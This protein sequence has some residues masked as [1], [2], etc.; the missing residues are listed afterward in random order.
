MLSVKK[1]RKPS[2]PKK[3]R[4]KKKQKDGAPQQ[5]HGGRGGGG[6]RH[7]ARLA[8]IDSG[9]AWWW[10]LVSPEVPGR[11]AR[12]VESASCFGDSSLAAFGFPRAELQAL[13]LSDG[14]PGGDPPEQRRA[15]IARLASPEVLRR[16]L[17]A[18]EEPEAREDLLDRATG[19]DARALDAM[20]SALKDA[21]AAGAPLDHPCWEALLS[22]NLI[23][24]LRDGGLVASL[25]LEATPPLELAGVAAAFAAVF[26]R[27]RSD[28]SLTET[29][30]EQ[31]IT[32]AASAELA[33]TVVD[34]LWASP[35]L[36]CMFD[37][38]ETLDLW[39]V[40]ALAV[41]RLASL[42]AERAS[43]RAPLL[44]LAEEA[45]RRAVTPDTVDE[46]V[47]RNLHALTGA[48]DLE[49]HAHGCEG[50]PGEIGR[51]VRAATLAFL[52]APPDRNAY[53][54]RSYAE[55][56]GGA[57]STGDVDEWYLHEELSEDP[58]DVDALEEL[59][60]LLD[61]GFEQPERAERVRCY[62][63]W[64]DDEPDRFSTWPPGPAAGEVPT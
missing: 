8:P 15:L 30:A 49:R 25:L 53:L 52:M 31:G 16:S 7:D 29:L 12:F 60:E 9:E 62:L 50:D 37:F 63:D 44:A 23:L 18:L 35:E 13:L 56:L 6:D 24:A 54:R 48:G 41:R 1:N 36:P 39:R 33:S 19:D 34:D 42:P 64:L 32:E 27:S 55:A 47:H 45:Y 5:R 11:L 61:D 4:K 46:L 59:E 17:A 26:E 22:F 38:E 57:L 21:L 2:K 43:S 10:A 20:T 58:E 14:P 28:P 3:K 51:R 40:N